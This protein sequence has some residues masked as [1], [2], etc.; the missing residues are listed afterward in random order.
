MI[1]ELL[2]LLAQSPPPPADDTLITPERLRQHILIIAD[3]S[4]LGRAT[5]GPGLERAS[6][7]VAGQFAAL[8]LTPAGDADGYEQRWGLSRW[9]PDTA[10]SRIELAGTE[11]RLAPRLG[12]DVRYVA[13][14][15]TGRTVEGETVL[16]DG[17]DAAARASD[18]ELRGRVAVLPVDY[19]QPLAPTLPALVERLAAR[20]RAV[21]IL[22]NRDSITFAQRL[23]AAAEPRLTPDFRAD[24]DGAP[25]LELHRRALG[26]GE[27]R[28]GVRVSIHL[29]RRTLSR[30][31][32]P[33]LVGV[34]E[35]SDPSLRREYV[36]IT[37]HVDGVGTRPG[38][39]DSINNGADDNATGLAALL[40]IARVFRQSG[41]RPR[42][43]ILFLVP[44]GEERG[45]WG[46]GYFVRRPPVPLA[47]I[48][49]ELNMD[50]IG[51]NWSD[52]VIVV[53]PELSTLGETLRAAVAAHPELRMAPVTDRWPEERIF[54]RS[55]HYH[56]ARAGVPVLFFTSGTHPD[57]HQPTDSPDRVDPDKASRVARLLYQVA[58]RV[59]DDPAR[60]QWRPGSLQRI[61]EEP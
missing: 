27:L 41:A 6:A 8:G 15:V 21:I 2:L 33:N 30:A 38:A 39:T 20:A 40:E 48:V 43:S 4:M 31:T 55:D 1:A 12:V 3:D 9:T 14:A 60:P 46:S 49:A 25:V 23:A 10:T 36:A 53:G 18:R 58:A 47:R 57:Y 59:A 44:S 45:L 42:R 19:G 16:L 56:F 11:G 61:A 52:S 17:P 22:G 34:L 28:S 54:Y 26:R 50:L 7:Y 32:A 13:G 24:D 35:G 37:A 29:Q 51:R 5:P